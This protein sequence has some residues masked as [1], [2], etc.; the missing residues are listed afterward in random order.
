MSNTI[1]TPIQYTTTQPNIASRNWAF[2]ERYYIG[3][4]KNNTETIGTTK[5]M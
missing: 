4:S 5:N 2:F 3:S 1:T